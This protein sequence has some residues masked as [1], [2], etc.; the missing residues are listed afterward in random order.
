MLKN[1]NA[2]ALVAAIDT[3]Y[4]DPAV[5]AIPELT[6][7]L[8]A[9]LQ[10]LDCVADHHQVAADLNRDLTAWSQAHTTGPAAL[11]ALY[12][13]TIKDS[14]GTDYQLPYQQN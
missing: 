14:N 2:I 5:Q 8:V 7:L 6:Q 4:N 9:A 12:L 10:K 3:A 1:E 11:N 13:E